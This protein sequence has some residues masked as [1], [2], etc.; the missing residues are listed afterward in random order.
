MKKT[1]LL[2]LA[3]ALLATACNSDI[4]EFSFSG[5]VIGG[6]MC[7]SSQLG[8]VID[9]FSPDSIGSSFTGVSGTS[10]NAVMAYKSPRLLKAGDTIYGVAYSTE[11]YAALNCFGIIDNGLPEV[12]LLS[13]DEKPEE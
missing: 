13:I 4:D 5:R 2:A 7:S 1:I 9:I 3:T 8:Y 6:E 12:I 11:S 10:H